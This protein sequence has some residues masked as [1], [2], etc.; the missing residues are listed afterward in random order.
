MSED[1]LSAID[2]RD[3]FLK[4]KDHENYK[5]WRNKIVNLNYSAKRDYY[6]SVIEMSKADSKQMWKYL[7]ELDP[8]LPIFQYWNCQLILN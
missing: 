1:I 4:I 2:T 5:I 3:N 7:R 6:I 8:K